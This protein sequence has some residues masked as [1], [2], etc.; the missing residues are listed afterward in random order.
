VTWEAADSQVAGQVTINLQTNIVNAF[1]TAPLLNTFLNSLSGT[2]IVAAHSL[3][4]MVVLSALN[5]YSNQTI[6]SYF[7]IDA[8]V[9]IEAVDSGAPSNPD[10]YPTAWTNYEGR[11][12]ASDWY[13]LF[14]TNDYRSTLTWRGRLD[15]LQNASVYNFYSSG[16]E[17]LRDY[18][19][20]PPDNLLTIAVGQGIGIYEGAT[21]VDTWAWQE[22]LKGLLAADNI[23]SSSH[24]GWKFG[25]AYY[26]N[27]IIMTS[28]Q[29]ALLPDAELRTNAFFEVTSSSFGNADLA[30]FGSSGSSYAQANRN[31][32]L[33]DAIPCLTLP[34]GANLVPSFDSDHNINMQDNENN[35]PLGRLEQPEGDNWHHS[36]IRVM[37]YTFTYEVFNEIVNDGNLK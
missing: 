7:M 9:A 29:A 12:W 3:G 28:T 22:K 33:S 27:S 14:P 4:N 13:A 16:E 26:S 31:R 15:N 34:V 10:M 18:P 25:Y 2:N 24:G 21:G 32:I 23:L 20:D 35:W 37:A 19:A 36:D 30:L 11:L 6:N 5:D 17:V 8:A 1:N